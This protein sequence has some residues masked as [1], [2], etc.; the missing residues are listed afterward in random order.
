MQWVHTYVSVILAIMGAIFLCVFL[1]VLKIFCAP[2][3]AR[4]PAT[5]R[6]LFW[7]PGMRGAQGQGGGGGFQMAT[8]SVRKGTPALGYRDAIPAA[9]YF[10]SSRL[11]RWCAD[12]K[13]GVGVMWPVVYFR[14]LQLASHTI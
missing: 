10:C 1:T 3:L 9:P 5:F 6:L 7:R 13:G 11:R 14:V 4:H 2:Y 12:S 8:V